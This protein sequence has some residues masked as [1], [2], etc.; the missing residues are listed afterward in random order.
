MALMA[1]LG[2]ATHNCVSI[3]TF[4]YLGIV[5][6]CL[7]LNSGLWWVGTLALVFFAVAL[8]WPAFLFLQDAVAGQ[9]G[10]ERAVMAI[11]AALCVVGEF[12]GALLGTKHFRTQDIRDLLLRMTVSRLR[13]E[14]ESLQAALQQVQLSYQH[15]LAQVNILTQASE[16]E[17]FSRIDSEV[18]EPANKVEVAITYYEDKAARAGNRT[19]IDFMTQNMTVLLTIC[20]SGHIRSPFV[21]L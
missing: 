6:T 11:S 12:T 2:T 17:Q 8:L 16:A 5:A 10:W 20:P 21:I 14:V 19:P 13:R 7:A 9:W 1:S 3:L 4:K 15:A 18:E